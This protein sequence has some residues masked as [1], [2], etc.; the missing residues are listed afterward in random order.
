MSDEHDFGITQSITAC[1]GELGRRD[2][3]DAEDMEFLGL[4]HSL[5]LRTLV[6]EY[7]YPL[8]CTTDF[9]DKPW[10]KTVSFVGVSAGAAFS[11]TCCR[12]RV[13]PAEGGCKALRKAK[14]I[15]AQKHSYR[16]ASTAARFGAFSGE[17]TSW[18]ASEYILHSAVVERLRRMG[19]DAALCH[20]RREQERR[21]PNLQQELPAGIY[22]RQQPYDESASYCNADGYTFID[23]I[24]QK[25]WKPQMLMER[26]IVDVRFRDEFKIARPTA[27][28]THLRKELPAIYVGTTDALRQ[29]LK[30][31]SVAMQN[32]MEEQGMPLPSWRTFSFLESKWLSTNYSRTVLPLSNLVSN[33]TVRFAKTT[34]S[35]VL[36]SRTK[37]AAIAVKPISASCR[38][39]P[40]KLPNPGFSKDQHNCVPINYINMPTYHLPIYW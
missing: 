9:A 3:T 5:H 10:S 13:H 23:V 7:L 34:S 18:A 25:G 27:A 20:F 39:N 31:M 38:E 14:L 29:I 26:I 24:L 16:G 8:S 36:S 6:E 22:H 17:R 33:S 40:Y 28:Y 32:S 4:K 30:L 1:C 37:D 21:N 35:A 19:F 15:G 2:V 12:T 11:S